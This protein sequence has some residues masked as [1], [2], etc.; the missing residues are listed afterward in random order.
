MKV[1]IYVTNLQFD[2]Q[3]TYLPSSCFN[4]CDSTDSSTHIP[5]S[6]SLD[7]LCS[8][9]SYSWKP[10][11]CFIYNF[12]GLSCFFFFNALDF[13]FVFLFCEP[14]G[15]GVL[16]FGKY[17]DFSF[18]TFDGGPWSSSSDTMLAHGFTTGFFFNRWR[19]GGPGGARG[20]PGAEWFRELISRQYHLKRFHVYMKMSD[21][22]C[23][24]Y[25]L[26]TWRRWKRLLIW[27]SALCT[28]TVTQCCSTAY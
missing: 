25:W 27:D 16:R 3:N 6:S 1:V 12:I 11:G 18:G 19:G 14:A 26:R 22:F 13:L 28:S 20:R 2:D 5:C 9:D 21:C 10:S 23:C 24:V 17:F 8:H 15:C 7:T 4:M